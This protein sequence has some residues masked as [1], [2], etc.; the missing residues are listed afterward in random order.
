MKLVVLSSQQLQGQTEGW[1]CLQILSHDAPVKHPSQRHK[2]EIHAVVSPWEFNWPATEQFQK[3]NFWSH[4]RHKSLLHGLQ[5]L[6]SCPNHIYSSQGES[7]S[8]QVTSISTF[9]STEEI[10]PDPKAEEAWHHHFSSAWTIEA[11]LQGNRKYLSKKKWKGL[12]LPNE[13]WETCQPCIQERVQHTKANQA[14]LKRNCIWTNLF[15]ALPHHLP[16]H[17]QLVALTPFM[18]FLRWST[19]I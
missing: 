13:I 12:F 2:T 4:R 8:F 15:N 16:P 7:F 6:S 10:L 5:Y 9:P 14:E 11:F 19:G 1:L 17:R 18:C 3:R